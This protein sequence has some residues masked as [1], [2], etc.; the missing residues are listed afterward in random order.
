M[1]RLTESAEAATETGIDETTHL[2]GFARCVF[3]A[4]I[5]DQTAQNPLPVFE[6]DILD[7][8]SLDPSFSAGTPFYHPSILLRNSF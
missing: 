7:T 1:N 5:F 8:L 6:L 2:V 3:L 4:L